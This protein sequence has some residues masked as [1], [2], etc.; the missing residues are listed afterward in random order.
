MAEY[1]LYWSKFEDSNKR[2]GLPGGFRTL[3]DARECAYAN[4]VTNHPIE[5]EGSSSG[6]VIKKV[7]GII[8]SERTTRSGVIRQYVLQDGS[9]SKV[10]AAPKSVPKTTKSAPKSKAAPKTKSASKSKAAPKTKS[11]SKTKTTKSVS[12]PKPDTKPKKKRD[13]KKIGND[14]FNAAIEFGVGML[15]GL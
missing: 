8:Y 1:W 4:V 5:I 11:V 7:K 12:E 10:N 15:S 2:P 6:E 13:L 14:V 3:K 9:L